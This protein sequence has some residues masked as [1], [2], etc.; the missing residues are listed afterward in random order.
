MK[1]NGVDSKFYVQQLMKGRVD[2]NEI[3]R[4][5]EA[6]KERKEQLMQ[7]RRERNRK[8]RKQEERE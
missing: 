3:K 6:D 5:Y 1:I 2:P 4:R 8:E 7:N